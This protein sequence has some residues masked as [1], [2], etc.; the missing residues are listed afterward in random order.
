MNQA[1]YCK[2][3]GKP[4]PMV[5]YETWGERSEDWKQ[6]VK[7]KFCSRQCSMKFRHREPV[8]CS[9]A[10]CGAQLLRKNSHIREGHS[11]YCSKECKSK[12]HTITKPC[13]VCGKIVTKPIS[14]AKKAHHFV[15]GRV[16]SEILRIKQ[17]K[18]E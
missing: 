8:Q 4:I 10:Y 16:C 9:C 3:C 15:C 14:T 7:R 5:Y 13:E 11:I 1:I 2:A 18:V 17:A 12:A 6:Y